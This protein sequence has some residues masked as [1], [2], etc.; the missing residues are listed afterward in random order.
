M[1]KLNEARGRGSQEDI[2][3]RSNAMLT[4]GEDCERVK[5]IV[6]F[7]A[8]KSCHIPPQGDVGMWMPRGLIERV[9][10]LS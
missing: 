1:R 8:P 3:D 6:S 2:P 7:L 4:R 9:N 5:C 10:S